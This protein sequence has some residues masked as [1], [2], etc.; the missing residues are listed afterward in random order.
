MLLFMLGWGW[1]CW[2][3]CLI[4]PRGAK[5]GESDDRESGLKVWLGMHFP[6]GREDAMMCLLIEIDFGD[7]IWRNFPGLRLVGFDYFNG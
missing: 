2:W 4:K 5:R 6:S 7:I 1:F 3:F